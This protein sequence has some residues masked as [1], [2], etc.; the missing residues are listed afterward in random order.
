MHNSQKIILIILFFSISAINI[1]VADEIYL[2]NGDKISGEIREES[3]K[4]VSIKSE[5][6][7][8]VTIDRRHIENI[9]G[10]EKEVMAE[11]KKKDTNIIWKREISAAYNRATGNTQKS[12]LSLGFFINRNN[13]HV[14]E[15]TLKGNAYYSS[16]SR[17]MDTQKYYGM[18]RYAFSFGPNKSWYNF[19]RIEAD[20]DRF[21]S[22]DYRLVPAAG[23]GYWFYDLPEL[24]FMAEIGAGWEH[25]NFR[26]QTEDKDE[27]I[28][29]P[30]VFFEK[31]LYKNSTIS[32]NLYYYPTL[33]DFNIYRLHSETVFS[34]A[35]NDKLSLRLSLID[36]YSSIP[37]SDIKNNDLR[38][39]SSLV[40]SF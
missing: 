39:V 9:F 25:T 31:Q 24:K 3:G 14:D 1:S 32:Q 36:D 20:H 17:K 28:L 6:L 38:L 2:K 21:A 15:I 33:E 23:V 27:A 34:V 11:T 18:G 30:R 37:S 12:Q 7:G 8:V 29:T 10:L 22:I 35:M 16:S 40:Y 13:K 4:T 5:V 19:Y 26:D